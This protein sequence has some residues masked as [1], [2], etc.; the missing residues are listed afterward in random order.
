MRVLLLAL[1]AA[2]SYAQTVF[3]VS[4]RPDLWEQQGEPD[5]HA[6]HIWKH[7]IFQAKGAE[8]RYLLAV[9]HPLSVDTQIVA[10]WFNTQT[11]V[12]GEATYYR[13]HFD[14]GQIAIVYEQTWNDYIEL[15]E[16]ITGFKPGGVAPTP[17]KSS[18]E[19]CVK[20]GSIWNG[21]ECVST[22]MDGE[23][24]YV[25]QEGCAIWRQDKAA[26]E[27]CQKQTACIDCAPLN[28]CVWIVST[29]TCALYNHFWI[30]DYIIDQRQ[31]PTAEPTR[32]PTYILSWP[33][34]T[35]RPTNWPTNFPTTPKPTRRPTRKPTTSTTRRGDTGDGF[36]RPTLR[37]R[38]PVRPRTTPRPRPPHTTRRITTKPPRPTPPPYRGPVH[39]PNPS[40]PIKP[41]NPSFPI[42]P[43]HPIKPPNPSHPIKPPNPSHPI[44]PPNPSH[45][46]HPHPHKP[47]P[48][49]TPSHPI[50]L[51]GHEPP[52]PPKPTPPPY[53]GPYNQIG[54]RCYDH[55]GSK[56]FGRYYKG[57][58]QLEQCKQKCNAD[59]KCVGI[60]WRYMHRHTCGL[61]KDVDT[62][63]SSSHGDCNMQDKC[64]LV[65]ANGGGG[66]T[67]GGMM[68]VWPGWGP[69]W[70]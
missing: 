43:H 41:P 50:P 2:I 45:P 4:Y 39:P 16:L 55:A 29:Q 36:G 23:P 61:H 54:R 58:E 12:Q 46:I 56:K 22:C 13:F 20:D 33:P 15:K 26:T 5:A 40:H 70:G 9:G 65:K 30:P 59:P 8:L 3:D 51:P 69:G 18:C 7:V 53:R 32:L 62:A 44:K 66:G 19:F 31:C 17:P 35:S 1:F 60:G 34:T 11:R 6:M 52:K 21:D 49:P 42:P 57:H 68:P 10:S 24:C 14:T 38:P 37:P 64:C 28:D 25:G 47:I 27:K 63:A 67:G 48:L